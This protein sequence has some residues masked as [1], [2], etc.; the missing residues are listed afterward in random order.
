MISVLKLPPNKSGR[1][2][3]VGDIHGSFSLLEEALDAA[4][5]NPDRDRL[6]CVGD[7]VNRGPESR[8]SLEFLEKSWFFSLRGNHDND[9]ARHLA[10]M[11][12]KGRAAVRDEFTRAGRDWMLE[13]TPDE[14]AI[15]SRTLGSLPYLIEIPLADGSIAG[16]VHAEIPEGPTWREFVDLIEKGC[17]DAREAAIRQRKRIVEAHN[18]NAVRLNVE[19]V[20]RLFTGHTLAA[21]RGPFVSGNWCLLDTGASNRALNVQDKTF[22]NTPVRDYHLTLADVNADFGALA[23]RKRPDDDRPFHVIARAG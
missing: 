9:I 18:N 12:L 4:E 19:G 10:R 2:F 3:A 15:Y 11:N 5:F 21:N 8:R 6:V 14:Q 13:L 7:L 20:D 17:P 1:D 22:P 16:F 23:R